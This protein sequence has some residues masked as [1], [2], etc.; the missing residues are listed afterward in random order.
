MKWSS[1]LRTG[2]FWGFLLVPAVQP[3]R[4][5]VTP[6]RGR[7]GQEL[8]PGDPAQAGPG[9]A[10]TWLRFGC[11]GLEATSGDD[12]TLR[13]LLVCP[14]PHVGRAHPDTAPGPQ[15]LSKVKQ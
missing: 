13:A 1:E 5:Q 4:A 11:P 7:V 3:R 8:G 2:V 12:A 14:D 15:N 9:L 10:L 6:G